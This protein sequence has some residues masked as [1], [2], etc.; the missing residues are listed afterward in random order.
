MTPGLYNLTAENYHADPAPT[1]SLSSSIAKILLDKSPMHAWMAHPRLNPNFEREEDSRF[2]LG[3]AAHMMLLERRT[4][5]IVRV[6]ADDW[7]TKAA[8]EARDT[9]RANGQFAILERQFADVMAM[10]AA[11]QN[12]L[13]TT[14]L[15]DIL[16]TGDP[17]QTI[18]WRD[19]EIWCRARPDLMMPDR[20]ICVDYKSTASAAP[21][22]VTRQLGRMG[23]DL[24]AEFYR[25]GIEAITG[26]NPEF[27]FLFQEIEKPYA[28]SLVGLSNTFRAVGQAK[29]Q[30]AI[31]LWTECVMKN[32]WD[33]Y[34]NRVIY[35]EPSPW[36]MAELET[37]TEQDDALPR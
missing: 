11:A 24:Q 12:Y 4:D 33:G 37:Q 8:K 13:L 18:V 1:A 10:C 7:R 36:E 19:G 16:A 23:Y 26:V 2:D 15:G 35:A 6:Q 25:R 31:N 14:E 21:E 28:C 5:R 30:H 20:R 34:T 32:S 29:V 3:S 27:V 17:E 22:F 9:A